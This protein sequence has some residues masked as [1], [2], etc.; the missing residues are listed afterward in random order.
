[1]SADVIEHP[2]LRVRRMIER[3]VGEEDARAIAYRYLETEGT[4]AMHRLLAHRDP[5]TGRYPEAISARRTTGHLMLVAGLTGRGKTCAI[6]AP[7]RAE[8]WHGLFVRSH[9]I[10][11]T[12][13]IRDRQER[14]DQAR[15]Y[16]S[17]VYLAVDEMGE[18]PS[19][20]AALKA[21]SWVLVTRTAKGLP[22]ACATMLTPDQWGERFG[23]HLLS[24]AC[25]LGV[26][27][28]AGANLREG[29]A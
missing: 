27:V 8:Q 1:M 17:A 16:V 4:Y 15:R 2:I 19:T 5:R 6:A 23:A 10:A 21:I 11:M 24:R 18:E 22:T 28:M 12:P 3:G 9:D 25:V 13:T 26:C 7:F 14:H 20:D 29:S